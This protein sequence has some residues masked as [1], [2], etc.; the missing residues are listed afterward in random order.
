[1]LH[2][3]S[4]IVLQATKY[5]ESS[6]I[7]K[8][9]TREDGL[10]AYI[11][12]GI[13]GKK[14][15]FKA[16][17][18]QPL[19]L[20]DLTASGNAR[21]SLARISEISIHQP[22]N[23]L[24]FDFVKSTIGMFI[25]EVLLHSFKE[26]HPDEELFLFIKN[27]LLILDLSMESCSNFHIGFMLQFSRFLGF[28]PQ[29]EYSSDTSVFDLREGKFVN[30]LPSHP[31]YLHSNISAQLSKLLFLGYDELSSVKMDKT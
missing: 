18:F 21:S 16:G 22:Y 10:R 5:S 24:P 13:R 17:I 11:A 3:T 2:K 19:T 1:M 27:S 31:D 4:G 28:F 6:L 7:I 29:G 12:N 15:T 8:I 23:Y 9:Y 30:Y 14:S 20:V 26:P 25:N